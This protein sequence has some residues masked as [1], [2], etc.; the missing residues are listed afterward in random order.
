MHVQN[1]YC[2]IFRCVLWHFYNN[3]P[4]V[5]LTL[6]VDLEEW[7]VI[8]TIPMDSLQLDLPCQR[9]CFFK[10]TGQKIQ[11]HIVYSAKHIKENPRCVVTSEYKSKKTYVAKQYT[12]I[13]WHIG[14]GCWGSEFAY[15][16]TDSNAINLIHISG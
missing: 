1:K 13:Y 11:I 9:Q 15:S 16:S 12:S 5:N 4:L 10:E 6:E 3:D 7:R 2:Y 14:W 8:R